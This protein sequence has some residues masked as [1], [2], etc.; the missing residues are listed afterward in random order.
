[1]S[2]VAPIVGYAPDADPTTPGILTDC[3]HLIPFEAG[4]KGA[5]T[6]VAANVAALAAACR[7]A[8]VATKLDSTRRVFAGTQT[9]LYELTGTT[10]TDRS[11]AGSY[12][13]SSESRWSFCQF[14]DT[15]IASNKTDAMQGSATGA[16]AD[17]AGAPKAKIVVSASN[18]FVLA[19]DTNEG[20]YGDSPDRWWCCAQGD[21]TNWTPSVATG[22]TTG[23]LVAV[24][25]AIQAGLPLGDYVVAYKQRGVFLGQFVGASQG[26]WQWQNIRGAESGAVGPEAVCDIGGAHFY[27]GADDF[28]VFDGTA[29]KSVGTET[30][31]RAFQAN[32]S[33]TYRY[34]TRCS[35]DR[36]NSLVRVFYP[37]KTSTG[38]L[39]RC[40]VYHTKENKW[41]VDDLVAQASLN[42]IAPGV[43]ID[44]LTA[45]GATYDALP[46]VPYDSQFWTGGGETPAIFNA[47][48]QLCSLSGATQSSML[49]TG[50]M[51]DDDAVTMIERFRVRYT[52][53]PAAATATGLYKFAEGDT[54][55]P[56]AICDLNEGKF[57]L[58]Q[59]GQWHRVRVDMTGDHRETAYGANLAQVGG[60]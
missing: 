32:R 12:T 6:P 35:F 17:I 3:Q 22:A 50:D 60:R 34:R 14:G 47:S 11:K 16:F 38:A 18:N 20:T 52:L 41:G 25:G 33:A 10:W 5:P 49:T 51:G 37:S 44:G 1:M 40:L 24:E 30:V 36:Q 45:Y 15:T 53:A 26:S 28:F 2:A 31:R 23:R 58:H 54:L 57:D 56:D 4:Y 29:P 13:G 21:Q 27:A 39:D 9:K 46:D 19:F 8:V 43:T 59:S 48:N 7:G 55:V 42:Y